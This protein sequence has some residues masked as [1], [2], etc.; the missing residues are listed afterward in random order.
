MSMARRALPW[1]VTA[2]LSLA[3]SIVRAQGGA[4][5]VA[6][7]TAEPN[8]SLARAV[9][10]ELQGLGVD[11]IVLRPPAEASSQRA[12]LEKAARNVGAIAAVRLVASNEGKAEVWVVDRVTGKTVVRELDSLGTGASDTS[13]AVGTVELLRASLMELHSG[14]PSHGEVRASPKVQA[15]A[16][17]VVSGRAPIP[18][19]TST[20]RAALSVSAGADVGL[21][22]LGAS[23]DARLGLWVRLGSA[24]GVRA[25]GGAT[26]APA[27]TMTYEG[28]VDSRLQ[29]V[30]AALVY[31]LAD[32]AGA[33]VPELSIGL[34][35]VHVTA[36]G[37]AAP[38]YA[39][40]NADQWFTTPF[41]GIGLAYSFIRGLR[42]RA[43]GLAGWALPA[44]RVRTPAGEVAAWGRPAVSLA[45]G[46]EMLW[47]P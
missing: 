45:L 22:G 19:A 1:L 25:L 12:P 46:I 8:A 21:G 14:E 4:A 36:T 30:G 10:A 3:S 15:L 24:F 39:G 28:A 13:V 7:V 33:W 44:A 38:P 17:P 20:P 35:G 5:L 31:D 16:L 18:S 40:T 6:I 47:F 26:V 9:R 37:T 29:L 11:V 32:A 34:A 27:R 41:A 42:V 43:D 2:T 23:F